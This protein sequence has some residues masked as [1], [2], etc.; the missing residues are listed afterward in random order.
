MNSVVDV[1]MD[2]WI[3]LFLLVYNLSCTLKNWMM[4]ASLYYNKRDAYSVHC[5]LKVTYAF[6]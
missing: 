6:L 5:L 1:F 2:V 3:D 4:Y